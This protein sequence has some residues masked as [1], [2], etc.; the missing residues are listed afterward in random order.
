MTQVQGQRKFAINKA[1]G[2]YQW[3]TSDK[4]GQGHVFIA[5]TVIVI[6]HMIYTITSVL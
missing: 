5:Y 4:Q 6:V 3:K 2:V 1:Q